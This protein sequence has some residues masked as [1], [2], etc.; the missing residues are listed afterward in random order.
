MRA[1]KKK[2]WVLLLSFLLIQ[3]GDHRKDGS[4]NV[5]VPSSEQADQLLPKSPHQNEQQE[6]SELKQ[7]PN[8]S[9]PKLDQPIP[10][11]RL[12]ETNIDD[13]SQNDLRLIIDDFDLEKPEGQI[14]NQIF[15]IN[16]SLLSQ[17]MMK[18]NQRE[19]MV[20]CDETPCNFRRIQLMIEHVILY[21]SQVRVFRK[22]FFYFFSSPEGKINLPQKGNQ[23]P[24]EIKS[25]AP[26]ETLFEVRLLPQEVLCQIR[27]DESIVISIGN[28][29][30]IIPSKEKKKIFEKRAAIAT[31]LSYGSVFISQSDLTVR[32]VRSQQPLGEKIFQTLLEVENIGVIREIQLVP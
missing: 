27:E 21:K 1:S 3:C 11:I 9:V 6:S 23:N 31:L 2:A 18:K 20:F 24:L 12:L 25:E 29:E 17:M 4:P 32:F 30:L 8:F 19:Q 14:K 28:Q 26:L 22:V 15:A 10:Y 13:L 7:K 5:L 16:P